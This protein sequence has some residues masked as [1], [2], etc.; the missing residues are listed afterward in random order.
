MDLIVLII[1][2]VGIFHI[3]LL[4]DLI[5][6]LSP[7][8]MLRR[9]VQSLFV[10]LLR[11]LVFSMNSLVFYFYFE[12]W[13]WLHVDSLLEWKGLLM[14]I[15]AV[16]L[17]VGANTQYFC[18]CFLHAGSVSKEKVALVGQAAASSPRLP[19]P[20]E[21]SGPSN[22]GAEAHSSQGEEKTIKR[23]QK[24]PD[25]REKPEGTSH[26]SVCGTCVFFMDHHCPFTG[27]CCGFDNY[28]NFHLWLCHTLV[29]LVYA[30]WIS[31]RPYLE[32]SVYG[33]AGVGP[34]S[35]EMLLAER[36]VPCAELGSHSLLFLPLLSIF[37]LMGALFCFEMFLIVANKS[38]LSWCI[39]RFGDR[40]K[41][42]MVD[43]PATF[44]QAT[45]LNFLVTRGRCWLVFLNP[46]YTHP[47]TQFAL[48][49]FIPKQSQIGR[50]HV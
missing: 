9:T 48:F 45:K 20:L 23:C 43:Y 25:A 46:I 31:W 27:N 39:D 40:S 26:C 49:P 5:N 30:I 44:G 3:P 1:V 16:W 35:E 37:L 34:T 10:Y 32:C 47:N 7:K 36:P 42:G 21:L 8:P 15:P 14:T 24:C 33:G 22:D 11:T 50:A 18:A 29:G 41:Q 38:T 19:P 4:V 6:A 12:H 13:A 17:F 28:I 2:V